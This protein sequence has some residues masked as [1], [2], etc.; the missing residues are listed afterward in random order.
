MVA[1]HVVIEAME[2]VL[3]Y[4]YVIFIPLVYFYITHYPRPTLS[5]EVLTLEKSN[6]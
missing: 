4:E 2:E 5:L 6:F 1:T 3:C